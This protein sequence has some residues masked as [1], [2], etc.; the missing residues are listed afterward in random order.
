[1]VPF[2]L[3]GLM[4]GCTSSS[5]LTDAS[6]KPQTGNPV[7]VQATCPQIF[8]RDS[9]AYHRVYAGG[10]TDDQSKLVYQASF[11]DTTRSCT[12]N[13]EQLTVNVMAQGRVV[14]GPAGKG[15]P[16]SL[17]VRITVTETNAQQQEVEI[18][19]QAVSY[20]VN[21]PA[22]TL[23]SQ[24]LFQKADVN[25]PVSSAQNAKVYLAFDT[26]APA[27]GKAKKK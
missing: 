9:G 18:Y 12:T 26:A 6:P 21:I 5:G 4:A 3:L 14:A 16:V 20:P 19:S 22:D 17:P 1:M 10:A 27:K 15:G 25:I 11:A 7:V 8:M 24:F 23:S 2:T 13:G